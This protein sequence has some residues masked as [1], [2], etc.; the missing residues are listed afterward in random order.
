MSIETDRLVLRPLLPSDGD[1]FAEMHADAEV[2]RDYGAPFTRAESDAKLER[3]AEAFARLGYGR[4]A[5]DSRG[6]GFVGYV[7]I[8]PIHERH[9]SLGAGVEVG[10]RLVRSAWGQ[11]YA[12]E[13]AR[14]VFDDGFRLRGFREIIAFTARD[15]LRSQAVMVRLGMARQ[16]MRDFT[17]EANGRVY[18]SIVYAQAAP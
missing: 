6:G 4:M 9:V 17:F 8:L 15:N 13:A 3:Y 2:M 1:A 10:W 16:P 7:G 11:G 14:A 5:V 18:D 12:T